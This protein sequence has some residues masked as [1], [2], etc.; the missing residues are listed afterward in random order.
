MTRRGCGQPKAS[1]MPRR[2]GEAGLHFKC[3]CE[4]IDTLLPGDDPRAATTAPT[5]AVAVPDGEIRQRGRRPIQ[6]SSASAS[7][8]PAPTASTLTPAA[9]HPA[10]AASRAGRRQACADSRLTCP[11]APRR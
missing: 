10:T 3:A 4:N 6:R 8:G 1:S 11:R 2:S 5:A 9:P 7:S